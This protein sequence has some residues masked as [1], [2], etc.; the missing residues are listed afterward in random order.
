MLHPD[1]G[2]ARGPLTVSKRNPR[3]FMVPDG[4][5][6]RAVYLTGSHINNNFHDGM[7]PG[8]DCAEDPERFDFDGYLKMLAEHGHNFIRL[9]RWEQFKGWLAPVGVHFCMSPQPW[10]RVGPG[11]ARDG[12]PKFDLSAFDDAYFDRLR[13][14]VVA[15]GDQGIYV[16]V[17]LFEGFSLHLTSTPD[18]IE[19]HPFHA[20]NNVS[21]VGIESIVDYQVLPLAA[22]IQE[23]QEAYI[24]NV[25]DTLHDLPNVLYEVANESSGGGSA[26]KD[27][28]KMMGL[29]E[30]PEWGD[31]TD[32][33]YWV[34][35]VVRSYEK[36]K[37][38]LRHPIGMTMQ[39][40]VKDQARVNE[41]LYR[42]TADW[43]SPGFEESGINPADPE[44]PAPK[45]L[46]DPPANDGR[47][48]VISD[49]DH[50]GPGKGDALWAWK[51]FLR[52]LNPIL[53]DFGIMGFSTPPDPSSGSPGTPP[54][55][56][57][58]PARNAMGDTRRYAERVRLVD[59]EPRGDLSSTGYALA[60]PGRE[61]LILQPDRSADSFQAALQAGN[62]AVEWFGLNTRETAAGH[63]LALEKDGS[64][65]FKTPFAKSE[66]AVV[67]LRRIAQGG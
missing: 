62:Y 42:S 58:E 48:I 2:S 5:D 43:I 21:G 22:Q 35:D 12:K 52:G 41:P 59:M 63:D 13:D 60:N 3:Y 27:F 11:A 29:E 9:W 57:F 61:Y 8:R 51:S 4:E 19:G 65:E 32:W 66:P 33:Q 53:Y 34:I 49:T 47:K 67:Y 17:M 6:M 37:G 56:A 64:Q 25:V 23:L 31:S 46:E 30:A 1:Q 28:A 38:Y 36:E 45:L 54:P 7:G 10:Q 18:N 55:E 15:A 26:D 24:R 39:F 16:S 44:S 14:R 20:A 50:Y 40:P